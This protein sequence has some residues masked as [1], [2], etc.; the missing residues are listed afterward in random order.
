MSTLDALVLIVSERTGYPKEMLD[1]DL[2][3][4]A[5]LGIDSIKRIEV[6]GQL[7]D[8]LGLGGMSQGA[9]ADALEE[10]A[11]MKTMRRIA[12]WLDARA[13]KAA[14]DIPPAPASDVRQ[15]RPAG[16]DPAR[17]TAIGKVA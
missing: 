1:Q 3:M 16:G 17:G 7:R 4:E 8:R 14:S 13:A 9:R 5:D 15:L 11:R 2:D 10:L 12:D 6:L